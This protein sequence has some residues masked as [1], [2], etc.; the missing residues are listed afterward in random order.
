MKAYNGYNTLYQQGRFSEAE[1]NRP[2]I[3]GGCLV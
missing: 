1:L 3:A 2:G